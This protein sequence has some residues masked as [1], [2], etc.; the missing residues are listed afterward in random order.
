MDF[1]YTPVQKKRVHMKGKEMNVSV[2]KC[3]FIGKISIGQEVRESISG[4]VHSPMR[5]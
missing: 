4:Q 2:K 1:N 5:M 3:I